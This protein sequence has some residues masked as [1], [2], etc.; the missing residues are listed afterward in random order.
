LSLHVCVV[1]GVSSSV[2]PAGGFQ[3]STAG[4]EACMRQGQQQ[5]Y[6]Q[7]SPL[8]P[9]NAAHPIACVCGPDHVLSGQLNRNSSTAT[10]R[11]H[12][13]LQ[14]TVQ[15]SDVAGHRKAA[16]SERKQTAIPHTCSQHATCDSHHGAAGLV[17]WA[18][19]LR[20]GVCSVKGFSAARFA[21]QK[22]Q[23]Q[24]HNHSTP[25]YMHARPSTRSYM[26]LQHIAN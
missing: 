15:S 16:S 9:D 8:P 6:T 22:Q 1:C 13:G 14:D 12:N 19:A 5:E 20:S 25:A 10:A 17:P 11:C 7:Q 3:V 18:L 24:P 2:V 26:L 4:E 23:R 21:A